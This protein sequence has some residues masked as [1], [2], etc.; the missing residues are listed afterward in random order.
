M[1]SNQYGALIALE[2]KDSLDIYLDSGSHQKYKDYKLIKDVLDDAL[3]GYSYREGII[4]RKKI[5]GE[6]STHSYIK[7]SSPTSSRRQAVRGRPDTSSII[8]ESI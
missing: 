8:C 3:T 2:P 4:K 6:E 7:L 5:N 1:C